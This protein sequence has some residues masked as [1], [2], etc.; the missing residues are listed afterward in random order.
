[1]TLAVIT[2]S[3]RNDWPLFVDL[4]QSVLL[5]TQESVKHYVIVPD[6]DV[7][8][9]SQ[10]SGPR[11]VLIPEETL[12]PRHYRPA[13]TANRV[14]HLLPRIPPWARVAALNIKR[15]F[16]PVRGW[17]IQQ[18]LKMEAC[19][20]IAADITFTLMLDS[21]VVLIRPVTEATLSNKGRPRL[22]RLPGAVDGHLPQHMQWHVVSRK[23]LGLPPPDFPAPD[24]VSSFT[25]WDPSILR[26]LLARI[27]LVTNE[28]WMDAVTSQR[29]FS[30]WTIYGVFADEFMKETIDSSTGS[31]LCHSYWGLI[32]LNA[33]TAAEFV[34][35]TDLNDVAILIQSKSRTPIAVRRTALSSFTS[36]A[37]N[38]R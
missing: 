34:A 29:N 4:H 18:A 38:G 32:P 36:L 7:Q 12:Y 33:A 3:Y 26:A 17:V 24:Y 8:L 20:R 37:S 14:L 19:R 28:H 13:P 9:F 1:V 5:H 6:A 35:G 21:D 31:S 22:Y 30:E 27:E 23:L 11:C 10:A 25:V 2:P 15:P 16:R